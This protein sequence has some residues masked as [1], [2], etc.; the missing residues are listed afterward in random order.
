M[1]TYILALDQ[2]TTSS[3]AALVD[4]SGSIR[5]MAQYEITQYYP[6]AGWVEHDPME[7]IATLNQAIQDCLEQANIDAA[8]IAAIGITNQRE[9][10][11]LWDKETGQPLGRAIVWQ[12]R[13]SQSIC[14][15]LKANG[16]EP[17]F[18]D[19]TGLLLDPYFSG[20]KVK[21]LLDHHEG[22]REKA[23]QGKIMFGTVDTWIIWHLTNGQQH[24]TD[25]SNASRTLMYNIHTHAWDDEL[26]RLLDVPAQ[27]LPAI[28]GNAD[29]I[30]SVQKHP[31][32]IDG[33]PITGIAGDQQA[34]LF[35]QACFQSGMA[36]NTYG[37]GCFLLMNTGSTAVASQHGLLTSVGWELSGQI[38][39]VLEGSIFIAGS[40]VQWLRDGLKIIQSA[41]DTN[42]AAASLPSSEGV[43][44][45][46]AF[47]GLGAPYW[48]SEVRGA[49]FGLTRGSERNHLI[50]GVLE[51]I[52]YQTRDVLTAME[53]DAGITLHT[54]RVDGGATANP[55][56][57]QFQSDIL[58]VPVQRAA[59]HET[60][61][62][63]AAY[64]A[65][66]GAG[67][68]KDRDELAQYWQSSQDY[69]PQMDDQ[70]RQS[71]YEGW[72]RAVHAAMSF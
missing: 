41:E 49:I 35:G 44:V 68:W 61:V 57:M 13:Q 8:E 48:E 23:R 2:G 11:I 38:T 25:R 18:R 31:L 3:R 39:Y 53:A 24:I 21:W 45:V 60:T 58:H 43:Y 62:L 28:R 40:A 12:S 36:K 50:R 7:L 69:H 33:T 15:E 71:L 72:K 10:T 22:A 26:L 64:F 19:H 51:S 6:E 42:E 14:T 32:L 46:P 55:F 37:T 56:L 70:R 63:G 66:L 54:L 9:T 29:L 52:A 1:S 30:G 27:M 47:V 17:L 67:F 65:G 5:H 34:A 4:K 20:T 16:H 59:Q